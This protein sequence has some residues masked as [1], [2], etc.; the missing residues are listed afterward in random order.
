[1]YIEK[2]RNRE[3][4][5]E[6]LY[7]RED[8]WEKFEISFYERREN[9]AVFLPTCFFFSFEWKVSCDWPQQVGIDDAAAAAAGFVVVVVVAAKSAN[10]ASAFSLCKRERRKRYARVRSLCTFKYE[11]K[12]NVDRSILVH[13]SIFRRSLLSFSSFLISLSMYFFPLS[14]LDVLDETRARDE[15]SPVS[16]DASGTRKRSS[17]A[18][19]SERRE[20]RT[21]IVPLFLFF[22]FSFHQAKRHGPRTMLVVVTERRWLRW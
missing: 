22:C 19:T 1:M 13:P 10:M 21:F 15:R 11:R 9:L 8:E 17:R 6:W 12:A 18:W 4:E 20:G 16:F 5:K 14:Y 7:I 3:R 2:E